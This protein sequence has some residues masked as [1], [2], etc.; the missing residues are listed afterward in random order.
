M[1]EVI[2]GAKP[3][4]PPDWRSLTVT[5]RARSAIRRHIRQTE[6]EEFVRLGP[7]VGRADLR[8]RRQVAGRRVA[9]AGARPVRTVAGEEELFEA[10]GRGRVYA[11]QVLEAVFPGLADAER[12]AAAARTP[13]RGR[14]GR[15]AVRPRRRPD[16]RHLAPLRALLQP[17]AWRP[18]RR[19]HCSRTCGLTVHTIDCD[20][21]SEYEDR[22]DL[23]R[24]LQWTP[25]AERNALA[26]ARLRATIRNAPGVLGQ[27]CTIIGEAGGNIIGL[28]MSSPRSPTSSTSTSTSRSPTP[29]T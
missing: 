1:V 21:L 2:R 7:G 12:E 18:D 8:T 19:H 22:E 24:D 11:G 27:A 25:E 4:S 15:A 6:R 26:A 5:G 9:A 13:D 20:R 17:R 28:N 14:Q 3:D 29:A 23:W 10:V 16:A